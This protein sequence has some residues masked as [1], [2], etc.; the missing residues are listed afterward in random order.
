MMIAAI[1]C[2]F[3]MQHLWDKRAEALANADGV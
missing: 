2:R 1:G 3:K